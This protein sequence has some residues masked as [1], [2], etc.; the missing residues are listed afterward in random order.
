[1]HEIV[2]L[3]GWLH[4]MGER[5]IRASLSCVPLL[6]STYSFTQTSSAAFDG[7]EKWKDSLT[8]TSIGSL[9]GLY[10]TDPP[11]E[12][13]PK[14]EKPIPD[15]SPEIDFWQRLVSSGMTDFEAIPVG[16]QDRD[17]LHLISLAVSM[18]TNTPDGSR[19]RYVTEDQ[20]WQEQGEGWRI[21]MA[22]HSEAVKMP[23]ALHPNPNLYPQGV[24]AKAEIE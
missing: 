16:E 8:A 1:M 19:T 13:M 14:G 5:L 7:V 10:S 6:V 23:P 2:I 24:D 4:M 17:G 21:V 20:A 9:K 18:K 11:A 12:F 15:I 22:G 3:G